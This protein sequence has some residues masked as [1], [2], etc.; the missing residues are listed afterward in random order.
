MIIAGNAFPDTHEE[1]VAAKELNIPVHRYH[2]FLGDLMSQY[3]SVAVT[4]AH[5]KHQQQVC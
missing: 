5:G 4:G 3:T 2:H 1:I